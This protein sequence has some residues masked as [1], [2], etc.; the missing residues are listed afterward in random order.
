MI[1]IKKKL[2]KKNFKNI[3]YSFDKNFK[4]NNFWFKCKNCGVIIYKKYVIENLYVC[5]NC[6]NHERINSRKRIN[7]FLDLN[8]K[9]LELSIN[10]KSIDHLK[11]IDKLKY[12]ERISES[13][14]NSGELDSL[15]VS[16][17][18]IFDIKAIIACFEFEFMGGSMGSVVGEKFVRGIQT[19]IKNNI[20]FICFSSSGG[21]RMQEGLLSLMQMSKIN[22]MLTLMSSAKIV[23]ISV[24]TD[25]TMGGVSASFSFIGDIIVSEPKALIGFAGPRVIQKVV[26]EKLPLEF[27]RSEFL[28]RNGSLDMIIDRRKLKKK[29]FEL[30]YIL[31]KY[32]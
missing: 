12:L 19:S 3:I 31:K 20:P 6:G 28:L 30:I 29:I 23:F 5:S 1:W 21:A 18:S 24:L 17:G 10:I 9:R 22:S 8:Y 15:I 26:K 16:F 25:P 27:Q 32:K 2:Q 7:Y 14:K 13:I 4:K 11:F